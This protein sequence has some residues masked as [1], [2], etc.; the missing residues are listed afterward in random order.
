MND[1]TI[2]LSVT[3]FGKTVT[4]TQPDELNIHDFLNICK[5]L[6]MAIEYQPESWNDAILEAADDIEVADGATR[7]LDEYEAE[8]KMDSGNMLYNPPRSETV[9][10]NNMADAPAI[11]VNGHRYVKMTD[12]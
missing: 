10:I 1:H 4:I 9:W 12:C 8:M 11:V 2:T 6:A 7:A 3:A 5:T